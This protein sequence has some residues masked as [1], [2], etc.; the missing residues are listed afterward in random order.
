MGQTF[1]SEK[2]TY[3]PGD[4]IAMQGDNSRQIVL[5]GEGSAELLL[6]TDR[7]GGMSQSEILGA[8]RRI[9]MTSGKEF[10]GVT[11]LINEEPQTITVRATTPCTAMVVDVP[12]TTNEIVD[13]LRTNTGLALNVL[14]GL[15]DIVQKSIANMKKYARMASDMQ[16]VSDNLS[17]LYAHINKKD[18]PQMKHFRAAG[19][20]I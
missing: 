20:E 16:K 19:G 9:G 3:K 14:N 15:K 5:L 12:Q 18:T 17:L 6:S 1:T 7:N 11:N 8:S 2:K 10:V 13:F 4:I